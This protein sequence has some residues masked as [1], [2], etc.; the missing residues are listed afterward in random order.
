MKHVIKDEIGNTI[1]IVLSQ[2]SLKPGIE[3]VRDPEDSLQ[4]ARMVKSENEEVPDHFHNAVER[5][6]IGTGE[7]LFL[8]RGVVSIS[9]YDDSQELIEELILVSGEAIVLLRGG[10]GLKM[11]EDTIIY[12]VKQGPYLGKNDKTFF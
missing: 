5:T 9:I 6:I 4:L 11:L 10:H 12:E 2:Y 8:E 7:V 1:A 3:F